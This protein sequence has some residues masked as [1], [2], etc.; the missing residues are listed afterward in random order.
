MAGEFQVLGNNK[1]ALFSLKIHRGEGMCLLA[2]DWRAEAPPNDFVGFAIEYRPPGSDRFFAVK[3]R[4]SFPGSRV[5]EP[6]AGDPRKFEST[7]APFQIFRWVHFPFKPDQDGPFLYRITPVFMNE[8]DELSFG[9]PQEASVQLARM[10][11][12]GQ[13]NVA[14]TR[15]FVSSQAFVDRYESAGPISMLLPAKAALG[16]DFKP[17]HP[18]TEEALAWMGFEARTEVIEALDAA[19]KD[20]TAQVR[21]VAYDFNLPELADR[22][23][24][25]K[26]RVKIIIDDRAEHGEEH[27]AET[28][29]ASRFIKLLGKDNV[30][31]Q[32]MGQLQHNKMLVVDGK[33]KF[34]IGGSTNFSWRGF[35]VQS[36]NAVVVHGAKAIKPFK[37]AFEAYWNAEDS[38]F[39]STA[40]AEWADLGLK[41]I[42]ARICFSP[43][44]KTNAVLKAIGDDIDTAKSSVLFSL[45]FLS[46]TGG[47]VTEAVKA[48]TVKDGMFVYGISDKKTKIALLR[49]DG[50]PAPVFASALSEKTAPEPFRSEPTG[51]G[52]ARMHHKFVVIDFDKPS[53]RVYTGSYNFSGTADTKNGENLFLIRDRRI[54]VSYMVEALRIFDTYHFRIAQADAKTA[55]RKLELKKPP[56]KAGETPWWSEYY[57]D[58]RRIRDRLLFA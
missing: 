13:M 25:L 8:Q 22:L 16:L 11:Y 9:E 23:S 36:N 40:S 48:A 41:D 1:R 27:S 54:A 47:P 3:N 38:P 50:N 32:H 10:T 35:Y 53:A 42:D 56:R 6:K 43:H 44:S 2:M 21:M 14:F 18:R 24:R 15:G 28:S 19:I 57:S 12:P 58:P 31:R 49:P 33:K 45:A 30:R 17:T 51:G 39:G 29:A 5:L 52:G 37:A 7:R 26:G 34:A 20:Q 46:Q 4:L 55:K